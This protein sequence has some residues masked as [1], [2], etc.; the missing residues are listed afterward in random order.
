MLG[1]VPAAGRGSRIQPLGFS[2][3]LLP[4]GIRVDGQAERPC[5]VSE[6]LVRRM[7][8]NGVDKTCFVIGWSKS[9]ILEY[10]AAGYEGAAVIFVTQPSTAGS[11]AREQRNS[12][13][14]GDVDGLPQGRTGTSHLF[15]AKEA[16]RAAFQC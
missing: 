14:K 7:V 6:Y 10:Y 11:T 4:A 8:R 1:I 2:K 15:R 13:G 12:E 16:S 9:D 5:A 3:E